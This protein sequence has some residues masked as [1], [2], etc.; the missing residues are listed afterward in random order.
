MK[1]NIRKEK[2]TN[3]SAL[4]SILA[5]SI[6]LALS[7]DR[8]R[9]AT[10]TCQAWGSGVIATSQNRNTRSAYT[11][12]PIFLAQKNIYKKRHVMVFIFIRYMLIQC[13]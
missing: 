9:S 10:S 7:P 2:Q 11:D 8:G 6:L 12:V 4:F 1:T 13:L 5:M 3:C